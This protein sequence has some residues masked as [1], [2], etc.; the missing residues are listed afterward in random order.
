MRPVLEYLAQLT[1]SGDALLVESA[2]VP[3]FLFYREFGRLDGLER[4]GQTIL[5]PEDPATANRV[6]LVVLCKGRSRLWILSE[7]VPIGTGSTFDRRAVNS[8]GRL[9]DTLMSR[10]PNSPLSVR[11][12]RYELR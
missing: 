12:E 10:G 4:L 1:A 6:D 11:L 7:D 2:A 5:L 9:A 8:F 3:T